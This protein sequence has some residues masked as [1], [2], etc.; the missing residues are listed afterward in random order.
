MGS[1]MKQA[2][3]RKI[4]ELKQETVKSFNT[5]KLDRM[6]SCDE[7]GAASQHKFTNVTVG[8]QTAEQ[9]KSK[10]QKYLNENEENL[11]DNEEERKEEK[12]ASKMRKNNLLSFANQESE[13]DDCELQPQIK[14]RKLM[15]KSETNAEDEKLKKELEIEWHNKQQNMKRDPSEK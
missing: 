4:K 5:L 12:C 14:K 1:E 11:S 15:K 6:F 2:H 9:Y 8:L 10:A 13:S 7:S 3:N